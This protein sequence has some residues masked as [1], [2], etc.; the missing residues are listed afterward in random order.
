MAETL[1]EPSQSPKGL[2]AMFRENSRA[3][4]GPLGRAGGMHG[5]HRCRRTDA[6]SIPV[7]VR[8]GCSRTCEFA[9]V[10]DFSPAS[11]RSSP[12]FFHSHRSHVN[13]LVIGHDALDDGRLEIDELDMAAPLAGALRAG[14]MSLNWTPTMPQQGADSSRPEA[15]PS[16]LLW[17]R[18]LHNAPGERQQHVRTPRPAVPPR[19]A[20]EKPSSGGPR[21]HAGWTCPNRCL[22]LHR[23]DAMPDICRGT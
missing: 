11:G 16:T 12:F 3:S 4:R 9:A 21:V 14:H 18:R 8:P 5:C 22:R 1:A 2:V 20:R 15:H 7:P 10:A 23:R 13:A 6:E 17:E 19:R